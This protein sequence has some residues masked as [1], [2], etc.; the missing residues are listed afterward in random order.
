MAVMSDLKNKTIKGLTWGGAVSIFQQL[1]ALVFGILI[2]RILSPSDYGL[3]GVL[4]IFVSLAS[5]LTESGF[6]FVLANREGDNRREYSTTFWFNVLMSLTMYIFLF[7]FAPQI[8]AFFGREELVSLSRYVFAGFLI[9][10][11]GVV[12]SAYLFK[13]LMVRESGIAQILS[14]IISGFIGLMMALSGFGYWG[15]ATQGVVASITRTGILWYFSPFRP[16]LCFDRKFIRET[17][18]D[19]IRYTVPNLFGNISENIYSV[20]L[21][22]L[23]TVEDVG[24]YAEAN[25]FNTYG[26]ITISSMLRNVSQPMLVQIHNKNAKLSAFRKLFRLTCMLAF[27]ALFCLSFVAP[28]FIIVVL[29]EK[30][31][32]S[33]IIM[34]I[35]CL[36]GP[37]GVLCTLFSY[38]VVSERRSNLYMWIGVSNSICLIIVALIA[39]HGGALW[40]AAA[41]TS[42]SV[43]FFC[44]YFI[45]TRDMSGYSVKMLLCDIV[46]VFVVIVMSI[47]FTKVLI[48][49]ISSSS[50]IVLF[51]KPLLVI[52]LF[53]LFISF[54]HYD[55]FDETYLFFK[56]KVRNLMK[57][58]CR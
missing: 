48:Y 32:G 34:R 47:I 35:L 6:I 15:I 22:K 17:M 14:T 49:P 2:A 43:V 45:L 19:G 5:L 57:R 28:E 4:T 46:P 1:I 40:L 41:C 33:I 23:Y 20:L 38:Y 39:S 29:G 25:K 53:C 30:W 58:M 56:S 51:V 36:G 27:P 13:R 37:F 44:L 31:S 42:L 18:S 54:L 26:S 50:L 24:Y 10:S 9:S 11:F 8:A 52:V 16:L 3:V 21:G 12:Q 55:V 7:A